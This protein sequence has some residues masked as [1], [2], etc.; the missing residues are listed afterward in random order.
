MERKIDKTLFE[1]KNSTNKNPLVISGPTMIGKSYSVIKFGKEKYKNYVYI[2]LEFNP[3]VKSLL[4][5]EMNIDRLFEKLCLLYNVK[6]NNNDTLVIFDNVDNYEKIINVLER[7]KEWQTEYDVIS[8][9]NSIILPTKNTSYVGKITFKKMTKIDFEEFLIINGQN[10]LIE[11]I[12]S[13]FKNCKKNQFHSV[14]LDYLKKYLVIGGYPNAVKVYMDTNDFNLVLLEQHKIFNS[15]NSYIYRNSS[16][17]KTKMLNVI[18]S[19]PI[20]LF[21]E[22]KKFQY[23]VIKRGARQ[24]EYKNPIDWFKK[25]D[26]LIKCMKVN[27]INRSILSS[28]DESNFKLYLNDSG[29]LSS[30]YGL[31]YNDILDKKWE[32]QLDAIIQNYVAVS[33]YN[34]GHQVYFYESEGKAEI[35]FIIQTVKGEV[36]PIDIERR[37]KAKNITRFNKDHDTKTAINLTFDNFSKNG[38]IKNIPLYALFCFNDR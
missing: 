2:D 34:L 13:S 23:G 30:M 31:D 37:K 32:K 15:I 22:N 33:L 9:C 20:Q 4:N 12:K 26:I 18:N 25:T 36:I 19:I 14:A 28:A 35:P 38:Y 27:K 7:V 17:N 6:G 11:F 24:S 21:K 8:I 1:W 16:Y 3:L 5:K 29:L 10:E